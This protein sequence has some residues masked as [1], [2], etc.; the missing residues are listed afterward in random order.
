MP[1]PLLLRPVALAEY[2][3]VRVVPCTACLYCQ[4]G[5]QLVQGGRGR[6]HLAPGGWEEGGRQGC[7]GPRCLLW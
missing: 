1:Y 6:L 3:E 2:F 7:Q 5:C 4:N